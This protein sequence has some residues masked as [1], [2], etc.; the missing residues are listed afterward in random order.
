MLAAVAIG[1]PATMTVAD[2]AFAQQ[3]FTQKQI[4]HKLRRKPQQQFQVQQQQVS[5]GQPNRKFRRAPQAESFQSQEGKVA[6]FRA[7]PSE[8]KQRFR[9]PA[10]QEG[11]VAKFRAPPPDEGQFGEVQEFRAPP[12]ATRPPKRRPQPVEVASAERGLDVRPV[13][14]AALDT[15]EA[16][17][18]RID[19]EILF[20]YD[21]AR[22]DPAS[23]KQLLVLGEA[24]N[25][26]ELAGSRIVIAGHTDAAGSDFYNDALSRRRAEAVYS[27]LVD[28]VG[29]EAGRLVTEGYGE[30]RLKFPDAPQS[31]QN[32]RVEIINLGEAG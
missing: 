18:G 6:T 13:E 29:V 5:V 17:S 27:F 20:E 19:L 10:P 7:P 1:F 32:R 4:V 9:A 30:Q 8:G 2:S 28:Y 25:D 22:I 3:F 31:G 21:S 26:A 11:Q 24:L 16:E 15:P 12:Q 14:V 23:V